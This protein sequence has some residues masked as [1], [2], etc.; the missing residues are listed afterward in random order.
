MAVNMK[1]KQSMINK[2]VTS[3]LEETSFFRTLN[4]VFSFVSS[5][6]NER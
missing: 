1:L 3:T 4:L 2:D 5:E 6:Q